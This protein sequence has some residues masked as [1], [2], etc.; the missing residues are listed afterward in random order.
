MKTLDELLGIW[1]SQQELSRDIS[2]NHKLVSVWVQ[3]QSIPSRYWTPIIEA[4]QRRAAKAREA[5]DVALAERFDTVTAE[6]LLELQNELD[7]ARS[8]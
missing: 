2:D 5:G 6:G 8:K 7:K 1:P 4:A 3:R